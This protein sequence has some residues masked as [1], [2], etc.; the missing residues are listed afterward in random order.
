MSYNYISSLYLW[1]SVAG[2]AI[3]SVL[4]SHHVYALNVCSLLFFGLAAIF[5]AFIPGSLGRKD[6]DIS[7]PKDTSETELMGDELD[8]EVELSESTSVQYQSEEKVCAPHGTI[9]KIELTSIQVEIFGTFLHSWQS[10]LRSFQQLFQ[11]PNP[12]FTVLLI[13]LVNGLAARVEVLLP[14]YISLTLHWSLA[15]VNSGL[16]IKALTSAIMLSALPTLRKTFLERRMTTPQIDLFITQVSLIANVIGMIGLGFALPAP[17]FIL[18]LCIYTSGIGLMD[19]LTAY[20]AVTLPPGQTV[21]ELYVQ[22]G[23]IQTIAGMVSN[24]LLRQHNLWGSSN[25]LFSGRS[26]CVVRSILLCPEERISQPRSTVLVMCWTFYCRNWGYQ[27]VEEDGQI[28]S[29]YRIRRLD[30]GPFVRYMGRLSA[31]CS[32]NM[33][34]YMPING[35]TVH[36]SA[37]A[38]AHEIPPTHWLLY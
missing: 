27:T 33:M 21:S 20:G 7:A 22:T 8:Q 28:L 16:A 2:S 19:S 1:G 13:F 23:L 6:R 12:T 15:K 36:C 14:Q 24:F 11:V 35:Y 18:A 4:L 38:F 3:G 32:H 29:R 34:G 37:L 30:R 31:K 9:H 25:E 5:T 10:S 17:L 26:P